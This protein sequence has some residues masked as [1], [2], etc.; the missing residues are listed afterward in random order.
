[1]DKIKSFEIDHEKLKKGL[2]I[3]RIDKDIVTYDL[4]MKKPNKNDFLTNAQIHTIEH[5]L[6]TYIRNT[7]EKENVIY[8]GP[9]GCRTGFYIIFRDKTRKKEVIKIIKDGLKYIS[10]FNEEIPG[11]TKK[12]CGN[13]K[14]HDLESAKIVAKEMQEVL[15][16][17]REEDLEY[18]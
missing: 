15:S 10:N 14:E 2:Y 7:K 1:M 5:L 4:R 11:A 9:M 16:N 17:W 3:S 8:I 12:E 13:Y 6:A 18:Y